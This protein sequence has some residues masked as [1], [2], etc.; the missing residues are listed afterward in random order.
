MK[1]SFPQLTKKKIGIV[2]IL[3]V[4]VFGFLIFPKPAFAGVRE[5]VLQALGW[6]TA[7]MVNL[8]G[9]LI[10]LV[11]RFLVNLAQYN[12]FINSPAV[13]IGWVIIRDICNMFFIVILLVIA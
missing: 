3:L 11:V 1:F 10:T 4:V 9:R 8:L 7:G 2:A 6:M 12:D 5:L 13:T